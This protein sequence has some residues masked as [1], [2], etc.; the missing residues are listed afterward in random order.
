[1][2]SLLNEFEV[3]LVELIYVDFLLQIPAFQ[4]MFEF[5]LFRL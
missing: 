1:M 5:D 3:D 2:T 4:T